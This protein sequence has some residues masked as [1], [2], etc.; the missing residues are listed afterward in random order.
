MSFYNPFSLAGKR[1]LIT[2]ASSG[3]G[4][5]TAVECSKLGAEVI[6]VARNEDRLQQALASLEGEG[7]TYLVADLSSEESINHLVETAP[8]EIDGLVNNAGITVS[9]KPITFLKSEDVMHAYQTNV[10]APMLLTKGLVKKKKISRGSSI[11]FTSSISAL[12]STNGNNIYA[13][14][15][16]ALV[17]F[18]RS[19]AVEF[20]PREIRS[21]A[22]LPG[23]VETKLIENDIV[24]DEERDKD[25]NLYA[26]K[27][28]GK[29]KDV[30]LAIVYFLSGASAWVTGT[31]FVIDGG[32]LLK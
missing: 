22:V 28:Y 2:G 32:R 4:L 13:S 5:A 11:V 29:P 21:N 17:S 23:M 16:A 26:L 30:A 15:K 25:K 20:A 12:L 18:M 9:K 19:C 31:S 27:R 6:L 8:K 14:S 24:G 3:I 1:I 10:L 7:H